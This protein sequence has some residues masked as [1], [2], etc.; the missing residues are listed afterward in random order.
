MTTTLEPTT[1]KQTETTVTVEPTTEILTT[2]NTTSETTVENQTTDE[3]TSEK[4]STTT[5]GQVVT[6][7]N[8]SP[9]SLPNEAI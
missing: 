2:E 3:T 4:E 1:E 6:R 9:E 8:L 5:F 7:G